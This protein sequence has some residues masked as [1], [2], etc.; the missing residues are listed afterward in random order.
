MK[1]KLVIQLGGRLLIATHLD[2]SNYLANQK[3]GAVNKYGWT[4]FIGLV[5]GSSSALK[6][7]HFLRVT[8]VLPVNSLDLAPVPHPRFH[9]SVPMEMLKARLL[10]SSDIMCWMEK[11]VNDVLSF[12]M[13]L[14]SAGWWIT[15]K[16]VV[17]VVVVMVHGAYFH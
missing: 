4:V 3:Q 6:A 1:L 9:Y 14:V 10:T 12:M 5:Q 15:T 7:V 8:A 16:V 2:Q 11:N 17:V 13:S